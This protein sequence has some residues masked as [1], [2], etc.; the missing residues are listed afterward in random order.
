MRPRPAW[1]GCRPDDEP[2]QPDDGGD[3]VVRVASWWL[4]GLVGL[5]LV[6]GNAALEA[7]PTAVGAA[8][9]LYPEPA[10]LERGIDL[11]YRTDY[12]GAQRCLRQVATRHPRHPAGP[13][14][15]SL[16]DFAMLFEGVDLDPRR[17]QHFLAA[18]DTTLARAEPLVDHPATEALGRFYLGSAYGFRAR[19]RAMQGQWW[20]AYR[21]GT[22]AR[23][24]LERA[25]E[26]DPACVDANLGL[27][28]YHVVA[29]LLPGVVK[30]FD[31]L[32]R[33]RGD[34][35]RGFAE[36][37]QARR[38]GVLTR[39]EATFFLATA[40]LKSISCSL[41]VMRNNRVSN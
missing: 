34:R 29:D 38:H 9:P 33:I 41:M 32:F 11:L 40:S 37:E 21:D 26:L 17:D 3:G 16:V 25:L 27:G 8:P 39:V 1:C 12:A 13:L 30:A 2:A 31:W 24:E 28:A 35:Q 23:D 14:F 36:L 6:P 15:L 10:L 19:H 22:H 18:I 5:L 20:G 7:T 4:V